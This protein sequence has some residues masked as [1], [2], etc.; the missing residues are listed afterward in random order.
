MKNFEQ[1]LE[2]LES[3]AEKIK[4]RE[5]PIEEAI[6]VFEEGMRLSTS[7]RK[8]LSDIEARVEVLLADEEG[9]ERTEEVDRS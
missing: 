3:L 5:L 4:D 1:R 2:R 8:E 9:G 6:Q 7:L